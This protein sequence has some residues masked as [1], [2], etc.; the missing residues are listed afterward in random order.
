M[1]KT[2]EEKKLKLNTET[3][4]NL[5]PEQLEEVAGGRPPGYPTETQVA[6][7]CMVTMDSCWASCAC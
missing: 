7:G 2:T 6:S 1:K 4:R 5:K 3:L